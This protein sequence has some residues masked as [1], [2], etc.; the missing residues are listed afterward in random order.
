MCTSVALPANSLRTKQSIVVG[1]P[2]ASIQLRRVA[3]S[4]RRTQGAA[5]GWRRLCRLF[6]RRLLA[7]EIL[8]LR[9]PLAGNC[10]ELE[11]RQLGVAID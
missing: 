2:G 11:L 5:F 4:L 9:F 6:A 10:R 7:L 3:G 1:A 8:A